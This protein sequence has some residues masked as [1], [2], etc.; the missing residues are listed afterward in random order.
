MKIGILIEISG[1]ALEREDDF[2]KQ[3]RVANEAEGSIYTSPKDQSFP[4][5]SEEAPPGSGLI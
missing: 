1:F 3:I 2:G 4:C 5:D